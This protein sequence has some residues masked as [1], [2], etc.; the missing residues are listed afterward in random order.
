MTTIERELDSPPTGVPFRG[1]KWLSRGAVDPDTAG[2]WGWSEPDP[3]ADEPPGM[4]FATSIDG[5]PYRIDDELWEVE[6]TDVVG[7][8]PFPEQTSYGMPGVFA[9]HEQ[10]VLAPRGRLLRRVNVWTAEVARAFALDCA[11]VARKRALTALHEA[12][13]IL[14]TGDRMADPPVPGAAAA[15]VEREL[16]LLE[17]VEN[18][19][20]IWREALSADAFGISHP[21]DAYAAAAA[22]ARASAASLYAWAMPAAGSG[23]EPLAAERAYADERRRQ[24]R[25]LRERLGLPSPGYEA[26]PT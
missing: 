6:L 21:A 3:C 19:V 11:R 24:A 8:T 14:W 23:G 25:W 9:Q 13:R 12:D 26:D 10:R 18:Q 5:L 7:A 15:A 4:V 22:A 16:L 1:Y 17:Q 2:A 20:A